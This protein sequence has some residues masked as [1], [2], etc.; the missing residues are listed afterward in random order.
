MG[1]RAG[2]GARPVRHPDGAGFPRS[3]LHHD[4][5]G[6][7]SPPALVRGPAARTRVR[8]RQGTVT[9][10]VV[11]WV[12]PPLSVTVSVSARV[13]ADGKVRL[14]DAAVATVVPLASFQL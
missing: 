7:D 11:L 14:N 6:N 2:T 13:R 1:E 12:A 10:C 4:R 9:V 8:A 5:A 3:S